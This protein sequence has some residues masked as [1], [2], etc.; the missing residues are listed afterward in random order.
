[1]EEWLELKNNLII[2]R[3][4]RSLF[5]GYAYSYYAGSYYDPIGCKRDY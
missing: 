1:M 3:I 5:S 4:K 2:Y